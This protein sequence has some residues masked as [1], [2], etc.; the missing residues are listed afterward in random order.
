MAINQNNA[1]RLIM[2]SP[3]D[4]GAG[5][6][7]YTLTVDQTVI[8]G[9]TQIEVG[10]DDVNNELE[11]EITTVSDIEKPEYTTNGWH[12]KIGDIVFDNISDLG[13]GLPLASLVSLGTE[14]ETQRDFDNFIATQTIEI[15][16]L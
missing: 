1:T 6:Y 2:N 16:T 8:S 14:F 5:S 15:V 3:T 12:V 7:R 9:V 4:L 10:L 13:A 11:I